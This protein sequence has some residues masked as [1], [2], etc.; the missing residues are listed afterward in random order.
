MDFCPKNERKRYEW[1][2]KL[3]ESYLHTLFTESYVKMQGQL[4][5]LLQIGPRAWQGPHNL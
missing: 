5:Q 2:Y 3:E 4:D 1:S